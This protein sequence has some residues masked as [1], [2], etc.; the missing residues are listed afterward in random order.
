MVR[1]YQREQELMRMPVALS[2]IVLVLSSAVVLPGPASAQPRPETPRTVQPAPPALPSGALEADAREKREQL[3]EVM[4]K[5]PPGLARVL[6]TDPTLM[7]EA[8]YMSRYPALAAFLASHPEVISNPDYFFDYVYIPGDEEPRN[9]QTMA[10]NLWR[11]TI[12]AIS[13]FFVMVFVASVLVWLVRTFLNHRRWLRLS[14]VQTEVHNK[15]LDRFAG[16]GELL[17]YVQ[18]SAGRRFLEA[19]PIDVEVATRG[20]AA[21][22]N[23]ILWSVQVGVVLFV[24]GIGFQFIS[25]NVIPEVSQGL[26]MIGVLALAFGAG[27]IVSGGIS[28]LLSKRMGLLEPVASNEP[29]APGTP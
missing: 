10:L 28:Y 13:I 25:G 6:K 19:A 26:W 11:N 12:E 3:L 1:N 9:A 17:T 8:S 24:G 22:F 29:V 15:L 21:P 2:L 27:F 4:K 5:Y 23:R 7:Q 18:T 16:T 20:V 14:K